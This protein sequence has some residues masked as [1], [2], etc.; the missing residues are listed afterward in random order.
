MV[1]VGLPGCGV[2]V[3][4][5]FLEHGHGEPSARLCIGFDFGLPAPGRKGVRIDVDPRD[6]DALS[7]ELLA[8]SLG[9]LQPLV[10]SREQS[11]WVQGAER[12][13]IGGEE[14]G[15]RGDGLHGRDYSKRGAR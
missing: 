7:L 14:P 2:S 11:G 1:T 5:R 9:V 10:E 3:A 8:A 13:V 15:D 4:A 12:S 6:G